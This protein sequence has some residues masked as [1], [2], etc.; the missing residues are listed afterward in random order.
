MIGRD[1]DELWHMRRWLLEQL[2]PVA[3][4]DLAEEVALL[5]NELVANVIMHTESQPVITVW[6]GDEV[7]VS[8]HDDDPHPPIVVPADA[9]RASGNGMRIVDTWAQ[10]WGVEWVEGDGKSVWFTLSTSA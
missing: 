1:R 7:K 6:V 9:T 4:D 8:V 10:A 5:A 2:T 3:R